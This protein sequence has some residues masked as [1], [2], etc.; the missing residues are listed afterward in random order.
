MSSIYAII[1]SPTHI[2]VQQVIGLDP[3]FLSYYTNFVISFQTTP[4]NN[5]TDVIIP[6]HN[7][8]ELSDRIHTY[9]DRYS[10]SPGTIIIHIHGKSYPCHSRQ[11]IMRQIHNLT[12]EVRNREMVG[13]LSIL[14]LPIA[15]ALAWIAFKWITSI[16]F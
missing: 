13:N 10:A 6:Y 8:S 7:H 16:I 3:R 2:K 1:A 4:N 12:T 14:I 15:F 9:F 11:S 5:H